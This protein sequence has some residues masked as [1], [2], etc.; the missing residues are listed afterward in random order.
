MKKPLNN[1]PTKSLPPFP[2]K[3]TMQKLY[4]ENCWEDRPVTAAFQRNGKR[5]Y[6]TIVGGEQA[7]RQ[8][9]DGVVSHYIGHPEL[10]NAVRR[11]V[12]RQLKQAKPTAA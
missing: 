8:Y 1:R 3:E 12:R 9:Y 6:V 10:K 5:V 4:E 7:C 11:E 2:D